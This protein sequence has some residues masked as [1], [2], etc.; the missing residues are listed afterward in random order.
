MLLTPTF[1]IKK[2]NNYIKSFVLISSLFALE[3]IC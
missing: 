1:N 2:K 3:Y